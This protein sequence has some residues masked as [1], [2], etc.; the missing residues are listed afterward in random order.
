MFITAFLIQL[1]LHGLTG[2]LAFLLGSSRS[3]LDAMAPGSPI[4]AGLLLVAAMAA[5]ALGAQSEMRRRRAHTHERQARRVAEARVDHLARHDALTGLPNRSAFLERLHAVI[6]GRRRGDR[7]AAVLCVD[8]TGF[9]AI[10]DTLGCAAGDVLLRH[11]GARLLAILR[12][13][14]MLARMGADEFAIVQSET[15]APRAAA[16]LCE[17]LLAVL[18]EEPFDLCGH[19][20]SVSARIGVAV[21]P[22]DGVQAEELLQHAGLALGRAKGEQARAYRF[23]EEAMDSELRERKALEHDLVLALERHQLEID[24]QPQFDIGARRMVGVEALLRWQHPERGRLAPDRFI[25]LAEDNGM[26]LPIGRWVLEQ[27]C[28]QLVRWQGQGA[29]DL[30]LAV[31]LSPVQ[32]RDPDLARVV[33]DTLERSGLAAQ[34]LELEITERVLMED[35]GA[36]LRTLHELKRL[37]VRISIDDFG[38]GHS[39]FS[40]L[41]RFPFDDIKLDRSFVGA[42]EHDASAAAIVRATLSL[43][44]SLGLDTI[45]EGVESVEQ[46][47]LLGAEGCRLAQGYYFSPPVHPREIDALVEAG[48]AT[49][50]AASEPDHMQKNASYH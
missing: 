9:K 29:R 7:M 40:Y 48:T 17:R 49:S 30:R 13:T 10:N 18:A 19:L 37:G 15:E 26:I 43:G 32:F 1:G 34:R 3:S 39:S 12:E 50:A 47:N 36:N 11:T 35:T 44:R 22:G 24:Y 8:L 33:K 5:A 27:A 45:A 2:V 38:V 42:L 4:Y 16:A 23:F 6:G 46:L 21:F 14:D 28:A 20:T 25:P 41:R 31:N